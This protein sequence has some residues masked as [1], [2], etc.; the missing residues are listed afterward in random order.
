MNFPLF[1]VFCSYSIF[2]VAYSFSTIF[3]NI[4][5][6]KHHDNLI[7]LG[8]FQLCSFLFT[9]VGFLIGAHLIHR[10][11]SRMNFLGSAVVALI[12]YSSLIWMSFQSLAAIGIAGLLNGLYVGLFFAGLNFYSLWFAEQKQVPRI[13][14]LQYMVSGSGQLLTPPLAGWLIYWKGYDLA[15]LAAVSIV[16]VQAVFSLA[17]PRVKIPYPFQRRRFFVPVDKNMSWVG[18]SAASFGFFFAFVNMSLSIFVYLFVQNEWDVGE[19]NTLFA[20]LSI[21]TYF[22]LGKSMLKS[23]H[24]M[25]ATLGI[26]FTTVVTVTL[27]VPAP[28][29]FIIFNAVISVSLP[30]FWIPSFTRQFDIIHR[31]VQ[32]SSANPLTTMM[33]LLVYRE[34]TLC[35]GRLAFFILLMITYTWL[36]HHALQVIIMVLSFMPAAVYVLSRQAKYDI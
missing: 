10:A 22:F 6:W 15:F 29:I 7:T 5:I 18:F 3:F 8:W 11:G 20:L 36:N 21:L 25:I 17:T 27:L 9:F 24:E 30:M 19:W 14:G 23:H 34:F 16:T 26:I 35:L 1:A 31:Q 28:F 4:Y 12:L 33:E 32:R 2:S 13:F